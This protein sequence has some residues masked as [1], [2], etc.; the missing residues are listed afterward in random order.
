ME[1]NFFD[2]L[3]ALPLF[4]GIGRNEF[5]EIVEKARFD[6]RKFPAGRLI[7][8]QDAPCLSLHFLIHGEVHSL[9][10][11]D[12][13]GYVFNEWLRAPQVWQPAALFGLVTR[14]TRTYRADGP[15]ELFEVDKRTV[16][17]VLFGYTTFRLNYLNMLSFQ[18][19]QMRRRIWKPLQPD[20]TR[21]FI[22]FIAARCEH[23]TGRKELNVKMERL[24]EELDATRLNVSRMLNGLQRRQL[25]E[26]HRE[27]I[28]I[29]AFQEL[30][31]T[32]HEE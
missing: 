20:L 15:V 29:P 1:T 17:D 28:V 13:G 14:Y 6:F 4:Q 16:R 11:N 32:R 23:P 8:E 22:D 30:L 10:R 25:V 24:A 5:W 9:C 18:A 2:H 31:H 26:L 7:A 27:R 19:Q 12:G 3:L 21:R